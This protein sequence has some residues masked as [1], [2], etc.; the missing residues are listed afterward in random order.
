MSSL[1]RQRRRDETRS[2]V[3]SRLRPQCEWGISVTIRAYRTAIDLS[4]RYDTMQCTDYRTR[5]LW[6]TKNLHKTQI[7]FRTCFN[8]ERR[9]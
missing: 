4:L 5:V 1:H 8:A 3:S 6:T 7:L 2:T 9:R